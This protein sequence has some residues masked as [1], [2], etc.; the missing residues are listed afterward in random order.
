MGWQNFSLKDVNPNYENVPEGT[1]T[2]QVAPGAK[3]NDYGDLKF[4]LHII[5]PG[6][7][8]GRTTFLNFPDPEKEGMAWVS[9]SLKVFEQI[10][11][12]EQDHDAGESITDWALRVGANQ[13]RFTAPLT[14]KK[15]TDKATGDPKVSEFINIR[16]ATAAA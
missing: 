7:E 1:Y 12:I 10:I 8:K 11:G 6:P 3:V 9:K 14:H 2:Y 15:Y 4:M 5:S 13:A 16:K